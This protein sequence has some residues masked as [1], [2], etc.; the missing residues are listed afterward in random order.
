MTGMNGKKSLGA[1]IS[2]SG[3]LHF[4]KFHKIGKKSDRRLLGI[5]ENYN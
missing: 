3:F 5:N 2:K 1:N 4:K